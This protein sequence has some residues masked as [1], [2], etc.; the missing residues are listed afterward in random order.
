MK[1]TIAIGVQDFEAVRK[2]NYFYIDKTGFIKEWWQSGD[3]VTL[4]TRPR[5]FGKTLNMSMVNC[6]FSNQYTDR[7]DLFKGLK[8]SKDAEMMDKQGSYPLI[9]LSFAGVIGTSYHQAFKTIKKLI[10]NL[11]SYYDYLYSFEGFDVN[12]KAS[13]NGIT[14]DM[15]EVDAASSVNLLSL[16]LEKYWKQKVIILIDEYDAPLQEAYFNSFTD[17][18]TE[19]IQSFYHNTFSANLSMERALVTGITKV[20]EK[21]IFPEPHNSGSITITS[22]K[23]S[24][25]FGFTE[26]EVFTAVDEQKMT[27]DDKNTIKMWYDG[28]TFGESTNMYNPWSVNMYIKEGKAS[29]YWANTSGNNLVGDFLKKSTPKIK[30][31]FEKLLNDEPIVT[32]IDEQIVFSQL[33]ENENAIWSLLLASGYL[34]VLARTEKH[35]TPYEHAELYT[36]AL[37]NYEVKV[38]FGKLIRDWFANDQSFNGFVK[39]MLAGNVLDMNRYMNDVALNTFSS[40]DSGNKPSGKEPEKFYHG[41]VLGLIV[42]KAADYIIRSNRESGYG[43]YDVIMEPKDKSK[44]AVILEFKVIAGDE[45]EHDL[46]EAADNALKQIEDKRYDTELIANGISTDRIL[47]YGLAFEGKRSIIKKA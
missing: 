9:Y 30:I 16:L 18:M 19:F 17:E 7:K 15:N 5:R 40:F 25:S 20:A 27:A 35:N 43:R 39:S 37:A 10:V 31:D 29:S 13:L 14:E 6:F 22:K 38:M 26:N 8:I 41:F 46:N 36:L 32:S 1:E 34:K 23:Y 33:D 3:P 28:Y 11:Y 47:K 24:T 4:I 2:N 44:V 12:E 45:G 21:S 42:D